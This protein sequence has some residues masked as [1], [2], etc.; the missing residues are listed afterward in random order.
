MNDSLQEQP[1][2]ISTSPDFLYKIR[3][4]EGHK[5]HSD[6]KDNSHQE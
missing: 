1:L 4:L 2:E 6:P 3:E 5:S